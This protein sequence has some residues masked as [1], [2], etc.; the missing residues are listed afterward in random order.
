MLSPG[1]MNF[2]IP[3]H[4]FTQK[5]VKSGNKI[6]VQIAPQ[7]SSQEK[8]AELK[9]MAV[10]MGV[11]TIFDNQ[12]NQVKI[13][14]AC[15]PFSD[16]GNDMRNGESFF[17]ALLKQAKLDVNVGLDDDLVPELTNVLSKE[18]LEP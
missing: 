9:E 17:S 2:D 15:R 8:L 13:G 11:Q 12:K 5:V 16:L 3:T 1:S 6:L 10:G 18:R 7:G 4:L 14:V